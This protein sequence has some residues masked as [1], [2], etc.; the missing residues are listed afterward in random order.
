M[1]KFRKTTSCRIRQQN[2][3]YVTYVIKIFT[4]KDGGYRAN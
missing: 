4:G 3:A 1:A 2:F